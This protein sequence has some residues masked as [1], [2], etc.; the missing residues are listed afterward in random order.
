MEYN[1]DLV[2]TY[3]KILDI[4]DSELLYRIQF[5]Q[6]FNIDKYD[7]KIINSK[8]ENLYNKVKDN[9]IIINLMNSNHYFDDKIMAFMVLFSY[10]TFYMIQKLLTEI[11]NNL[12]INNENL[13]Q[14]I[15]FI[16]TNY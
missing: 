7:D 9:D 5:L 11:I 1:Y 6:V 10:K 3:H 2:C 4:D 12:E 14:L 8:V 15:N 13:N 16:K